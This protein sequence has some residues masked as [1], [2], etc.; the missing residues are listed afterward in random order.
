MISAPLPAIA[1]PAQAW[2]IMRDDVNQRHSLM[3]TAW[4]EQRQKDILG[5]G[6]EERQKGNA[7]YYLP[8]RVEL[9]I[10]DTNER[11]Q[12]LFDAC[13]EVWGIHGFNKNRAFYRAVFENC[14]VP[15]F[16]TRRSCVQSEL[17]R[18]DEIMRK[19]GNSTMALRS[20]ARRMDQLRSKW[21][22]KLD[23]E[24]RNCEA[25]ERAACARNPQAPVTITPPEQ[26]SPPIQGGRQQRSRV[27][28]TKTQLKACSVIF[29][30]I[31]SGLKGMKYCKNLDERRLKIPEG[32][33]DSGCP[34]TYIKA[35]IQGKPWQKKIQDQKSRHQKKFDAMTP[36]QREEMIQ[37]I[38]RHTL[39]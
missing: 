38:T 3:N 8:A 14:L 24:T 11:A 39:P 28:S 22:T 18:R 7:G 5:I 33:R 9:E 12:A 15:L 32:W 26:L 2:N 20:L 1:T 27:K 13:C 37:G 4:N 6:Y 10:R 36:K 30:A 19:S 35:Y 17:I 25:K 23:I 21:N 16:A 29:G 34:E 31:Q